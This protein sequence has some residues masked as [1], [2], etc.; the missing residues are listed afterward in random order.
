MSGTFRKVFLVWLVI[1]AALLIPG[2][3]GTN[4]GSSIRLAYLNNDLHQLAVFVALE[5]GFYKEAGLDVQV[6]GVFNSGPEEMSAF[7]ARSLDMGYVGLAPAINAVANNNVPIQALALVNN[8]GSAIVVGRQSFIQS[9]VDLK[10]K[11]VAIPGYGNV[12]DVLL[13]QAL[14]N[15]KLEFK[16][17]KITVLKPP[18]MLQ[19][20]A[21]GDIGA[22]VAWEPYPSMA[23]AQGIGKVLLSSDQIW[24]DH[25]CCILT[26]NKDFLNKNPVAVTKLIK[27]HEQ[28]TDFIKNKPEE[29]IRIG[30][31]YTGLEPEIVRAALSRIEYE[32]TI[33]T[34]QLKHYVSVLNKLGFI[35]TQDENRFVRDFV[36]S[37]KLP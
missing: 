7:A 4:E 22:F 31:K 34:E 6:A 1:L 12:Q 2:C 13:R 14:L 15:S 26:G 3:A 20:L 8:E 27:V 35:K 9:P 25:P 32:S 21:R 17:V 24:A 11:I 19:A 36:W 29:A 33:N 16:D 37:D 23:E 30:V 18:E 28:A 5:E 10:G